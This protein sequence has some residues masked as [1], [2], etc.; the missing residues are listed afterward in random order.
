MSESGPAPA[1]S[2][3]GPDVQRAYE[4]QGAYYLAFREPNDESFF[5]IWEDFASADLDTP[6]R[7]FEVLSSTGP[8]ETGLVWLG[9]ILLLIRKCSRR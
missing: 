9:P 5:T 4:V 6:I 7:K 3:K 2:E 8:I 1:R